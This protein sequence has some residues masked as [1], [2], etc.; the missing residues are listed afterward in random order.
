MQLF[1]FSD[2]KRICSQ[3]KGQA[4]VEFGALTSVLAVTLVISALALGS[5]LSGYYEEQTGKIAHMEATVEAYYSTPNA[6]CTENCGESSEA[7]ETPEAES[8]TSYIRFNPGNSDWQFCAVTPSGTYN[9]GTL[10]SN[11]SFTYAGAASAVYLKPIA[12]GGDAIVNGQPYT[13]S[14]GGYYLFEGNM[15]INIS[16]ARPGAMGQWKI[17]IDTNNAPTNGNGRNRPVSPCES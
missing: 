14:S 3:Q 16:S 17:H 13:I 8:P 6:S 15:N 1:I 10:K 11:D 2:L 7:E 9:R 4:L 5:R 12:G